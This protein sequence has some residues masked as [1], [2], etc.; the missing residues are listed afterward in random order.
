MQL[1][2]SKP[3]SYGV[4]TSRGLVVRDSNAYQIIIQ[5]SL[6]LTWVGFYPNMHKGLHPLYSVAWDYLSIP[7]LQPL[8]F[9]NW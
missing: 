1:K 6:L 9:G 3:A 8:K 7:K 5:G 4:Q 2:Y